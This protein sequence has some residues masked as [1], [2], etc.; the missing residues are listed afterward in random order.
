MF[1][2]TKGKYK[3][4]VGSKDFYKHYKSTIEKKTVYDVEKA[5]FT[6][7]LKE[8]NTEI[9]KLII[10]SNYEFTMPYRLGTLSI[11]KFKTKLKLD[12]N[13]D[14]IKSKIPIDYGKTLA[15]WRVNPEAKLN[16]KVIYFLNDHTDGYRYTFHWNKTVSNIKNKSA[17]QFKASRNNNRMINKALLTIEGLD[18]FEYKTYSYR[19]KS[20]ITK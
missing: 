12:K 19:P 3:A 11:K 10:T 20:I 9:M 18:F 2:R 8:I 4:D 17:Y 6:K 5:L 7:I 16:K 1:I 15:L 14:L 13:G